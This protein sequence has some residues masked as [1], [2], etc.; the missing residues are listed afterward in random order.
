MVAHREGEVEGSCAVLRVNTCTLPP[1]LYQVKGGRKTWDGVWD[2]ERIT[3]H[4]K[5]LYNIN[6]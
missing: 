1:Y 5:V 4:Q 2:G 3:S 6:T